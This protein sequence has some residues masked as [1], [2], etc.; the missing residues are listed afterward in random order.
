MTTFAKATFNAASYLSARPHYPDSLFKHIFSYF[1][2][3]NSAIKGTPTKCVDIGCG[4][5]EATLKLSEYF[6]SAIGIDPGAG[7][8]ESATKSARSAGKSSDQLNYIIGSDKTFTDIIPESSV[9]IVTAAQASHWFD[10][11]K[12]I[13]SS[14]KVLKPNGVLAVWGYVD[15]VFVNHPK[16]SEI[17]LEYSYDKKYMGPYWEQP[18]RG[19]L[20]SMLSEAEGQLRANDKFSDVEVIRD[21]SIT[22]NPGSF[23]EMTRTLPLRSVHAYMK[24]FS[25]YHEWKAQHPDE[26]DVVDLCFEAIK[27]AENWTDDTEVTIKWATVLIMASKKA[28]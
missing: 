11:P 3:H 10:F 14:A 23:Y 2:K 22:L 15:H 20:A 21:E 9:N 4:P 17:S 5:G 19:R 24:T 28:L 6:D 27:K 25:A 1:Q 7:M 26:P 8:I 18:G 12:F 16:A 13:E